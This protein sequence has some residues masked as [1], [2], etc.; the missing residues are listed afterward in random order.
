MNR[1]TTSPLPVHVLVPVLVPVPA[2]VP[3]LVPVLV[4]VPAAALVQSAVRVIQNPKPCNSL[5]ICSERAVTSV[6]S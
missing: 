5:L 2:P 3:I 4:P 6:Q 1:Q